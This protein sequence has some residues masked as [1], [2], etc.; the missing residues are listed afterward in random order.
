MQELG[1][2]TYDV[3]STLYVNLYSL[4]LAGLQLFY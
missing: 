3:I 4:R 1:I 2:Y